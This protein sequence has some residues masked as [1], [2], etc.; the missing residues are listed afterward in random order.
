MAI[1]STR[2]PAGAAPGAQNGVTET[3]RDFGARMLKSLIAYGLVETLW[4]RGLLAG[5]TLARAERPRP[6]HPPGLT[7]SWVPPLLDRAGNVVA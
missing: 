5:S 1:E 2:H 6:A 7:L 4:C 3:R